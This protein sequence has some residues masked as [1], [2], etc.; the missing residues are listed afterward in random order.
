MFWFYESLLWFPGLKSSR[1]FPSA[2][3]ESPPCLAHAP[4]ST[5]PTLPS[6]HHSSG[7]LASVSSFPPLGF[8]PA[9]SWVWNAIPQ[10]FGCPVHSHIPVLIQCH[11]CRIHLGVPCWKGLTT[12]SPHPCKSL[13]STGRM[14]HEVG[15]LT[16]PFHQC[17]VQCGPPGASSVTA[18]AMSHGS[19]QRC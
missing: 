8:A 13:S 3:E 17:P 5:P 9:I 2:P 11:H 18:E 7:T 15:D 4:A 12:L 16:G 6:A 14:L 1:S 10:L 19:P